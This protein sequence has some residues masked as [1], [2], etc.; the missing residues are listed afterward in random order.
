M[1]KS[2]FLPFKKSL[3]ACACA[4]SA[5]LSAA[6][7]QQVKTVFYILLE[8]RNFTAGT[9]LSGGSVV[10]GNAAAPYLNSLITPGSANSAQV[11]YCTSYHHVLSTASGAN[12]SIHPS[13]PN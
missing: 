4:S 9:D 6:Q 2:S 13:E 3:L 12:P 1:K 7:A 10:A 8:N 5:M 11:S